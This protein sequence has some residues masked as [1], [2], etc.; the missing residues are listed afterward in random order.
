[1]KVAFVIPWYGYIPGS[2]ES[3]CKRTAENLN[4]AGVDAEM[5]IT[6][7]KEFHSDWNHD[8]T[9]NGHMGSMAQRSGGSS[10]HMRNEN[11]CNKNM[12]LKNEFLYFN[13]KND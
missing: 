5:F 9:R 1:M 10:Q 6:C 4:G 11:M 13:M 12:S 8:F 7:A 3:K 2:A